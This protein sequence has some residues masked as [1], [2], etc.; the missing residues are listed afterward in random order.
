MNQKVLLTA[1]AA[2]ALV[3]TGCSSSNTASSADP[4]TDFSRIETYNFNSSLD[5]DGQAYQSLETTYLKEAVGREL[6]ARGW[7]KSANPDVVVNFAIE[8]QEKIRSRPT[9]TGVYG[10]MYDPYYDVYGPGWGARHTTEIDQYTEGKLKIDL[11]DPRARKMVWQGE[12]KG[13]L[14]QKM[15]QNAKATLNEAVVEVFAM[16]PVPDPAAAK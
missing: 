2:A 6:D 13:R 9:T 15:M 1:I 11:I 10:G 16:F 8:T 4:D 3:L 5:T 12:T 7:T 14:T